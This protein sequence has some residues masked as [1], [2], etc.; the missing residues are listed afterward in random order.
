MTKTC[1]HCHI[2]KDVSEFVSNK[3]TKD[4]LHSWCKKCVTE[5]NS[6]RRD[7]VN[8]NARNYYHSHKEQAENYRNKTRYGLTTTQ[9]KEYIASK[10][11]RC[12]ACGIREEDTNRG[13]FIHHDHVTGEVIGVLCNKCNSALG[14]L[15]DDLDKLKA[16]FHFAE[17]VSLER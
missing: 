9:R 7:K 3:S 1:S 6:K 11:N 14:I 17:R 16:L 10:G 2:E 5:Y 15:N 12:E 8:K 4:G 13:L